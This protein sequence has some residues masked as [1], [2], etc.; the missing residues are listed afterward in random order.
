MRI[1]IDIEAILA[2]VQARHR[3]RHEQL[4]A[5]GVALIRDWRQ[6]RMNTSPKDQAALRWNAP[7]APLRQPA[8]G[9]KL[10]E[11]LRGH[12]RFLCELRDHGPH[13]IEAQ[14]LQNEEFLFSRRFETRE[15]AVRWA[16]QERLAL[17]R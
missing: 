3:A 7:T 8:P 6:R 11:F 13:G 17:T 12:D 5:T 2:R 9:E 1:T 4:R 14:F 15:F 16:E 10:F